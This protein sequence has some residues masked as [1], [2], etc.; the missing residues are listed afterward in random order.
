MLEPIGIDIEV[1]PQRSE[2]VFVSFGSGSGLVA[3]KGALDARARTR[4][5][6][7]VQDGI[8]VHARRYTRVDAELP[9]SLQRADAEKG[10]S[11]TTV[12]IAQE[13]M[14]ARTAAPGRAQRRRRRHA[15]AAGRRAAASRWT[16]ES[17]AT[18]A[19]LVA[20]HFV[21]VA[22]SSRPRSPSS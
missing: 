5:G 8:R 9:V 20:L 4:C 19:T 7:S 17:S 2:G 1:L 10:W 6:S 14:L 15:V 16:P 13:G 22:A 3:L 12:N 21:D 18:A 11:G